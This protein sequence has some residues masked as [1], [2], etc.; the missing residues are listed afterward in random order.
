[1][2]FWNNSDNKN[3]RDTFLYQELINNY[4]KKMKLFLIKKTRIIKNLFEL[5]FINLLIKK[6][7]FNKST[8]ENDKKNKKNNKYWKHINKNNIIIY[9]RYENLKYY[10]LYYFYFFS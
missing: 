10:H 1:M 9:Y 6:N 3:E 2:N 7:A 4:Y 8:T 5:I